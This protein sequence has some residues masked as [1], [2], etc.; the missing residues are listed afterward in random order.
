MKADCCK[1]LSVEIITT[2]YIALFAYA[3]VSKLLDFEV[4]QMQLGQS[5]LLSAFAGWISW[6][7]PFSEII[8][9]LLL[10]FP[11]TR[12]A[13]F[14][15]GFTLM[16]MF[17]AYIF[18]IL[19]YSPFIPCSCGGIL[20]N[21]GWE[22]H[23]IFNIAFALLAIAGIFLQ[24]PPNSDKRIMPYKGRTIT[25]TLSGLCGI[26]VIAVLFLLSEDIIHRSN[27]FVRRFPHFP[28]TEASRLD[29]AYNSYYIAGS[30]EGKIYLGNYTAPLQVLVVDT[31]LQTRQEY[32]IAL[33]K[34]DLPFRS[35]R[36][37]V[38]LPHFFITDGTVP[39]LFKGSTNDWQAKIQDIKSVPFSQ[40]VPM[41]SI[42]L[43]FRG[44]SAKTGE[45]ILGTISIAKSKASLTAPG[46]L[47][48]QIDGVFDTDGYL[49]Y[50]KELKRLLYL[51]RYRNQFVV[52]DDSLNPDY[53]GHTIDTISKAQIKVSYI[54]SKHQRK[55]TAPPLVVNKSSQT[56][57][58]LLYVNAG[59]KGR[60]E[61]E[62][63]WRLASIIDVYDL[64]SKEYIMSFYIND[65]RKEKMKGFLITDTMFLAIIDHHLVAYK[66]GPDLLK[67]QNK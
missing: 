7:V 28:V 1:R 49:S 43:A 6:S 2:L 40:A 67:A 48:K 35:P 46:L 54:A 9:C 64:T 45:N 30:A 26:G 60:Y 55:L 25:L 29:L 11:A 34:K 50:N 63:M 15:A 27:N 33:N 58:N 66:L 59:L 39:C 16:L 4:F 56:H 42:T 52:A 65:I 61:S 14:F 24:S 47:S 53:Y 19:N 41:D 10:A 36:L 13:G 38:L 8:I 21:L 3:A 32:R 20:D 57:G 31:A 62:K 5:P 44:R 17:T 51:Y 22:E 12:L 37:S 23:L 18:I